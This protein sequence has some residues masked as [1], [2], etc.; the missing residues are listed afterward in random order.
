M[1]AAS[2]P[3]VHEG[4][5]ARAPPPIAV[6]IDAHP[7]LSARVRPGIAGAAGLHVHV[8]GL[9]D[10]DLFLADLARDLL[11]VLDDP[12][13][14]LDLLGHHGVLGDVDLLLADGDAD[15][16]ALADVAGRDALGRARPWTGVRSMTTSSRSTGTSMRLGLGVDL[17]AD[18]D[19]ARL[20]RPLLGVEPL[21]LDLDRVAR[22]ARAPWP[23]GRSRRRGR[24]GRGR[25]C[26]RLARPRREEP[27]VL[28]S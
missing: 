14:D 28:M 4:G 6:V 24:R 15:L 17:L 19:L 11:G 12:L 8:P 16:L 25:P 10:L 3:R 26:G 27:R 21:F 18:A 7:G 22:A 23:C 20:D 2:I 13:A 5:G 1:Q 9:L